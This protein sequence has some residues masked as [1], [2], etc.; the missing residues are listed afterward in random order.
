[1]KIKRFRLD[2]KKTKRVAIVGHS[3]E[4]TRVKQ[5]L[6]NTPVKIE[7]AGFIGVNAND[8]DKN[9]IG[10]IGQLS[11]IIRINRIDEIIFC[12]ESIS[13]GE[14]IKAMLDLTQL[15]VDYKI[16]PPQSISIIG[17]NSIHTSG[18]LYV[19]NVNAISKSSNKRKKRVFDFGVSIL[20]IIT[21]PVN[22]W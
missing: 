11:E 3:N 22:V 16:A 1:M 14:I 10:Q 9:Y 4:A 19:V 17:S 6:E 21:L 18:D 12:A 2:T 13:S 15:D 7:M 8:S 5:I 20:L